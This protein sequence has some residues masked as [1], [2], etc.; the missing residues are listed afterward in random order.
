M[1]EQLDI[2]QFGGTTFRFPRYV[3]PG[4]PNGKPTRASTDAVDAHY[5]A[6]D[7]RDRVLAKAGQV[8]PVKVR[9]APRTYPA[10][11][12]ASNG[13]FVPKLGEPGATVTVDDGREGCVMFPA[14][15]VGEVWVSFWDGAWP[16]LVR[17]H[18]GDKTRGFLTGR[19]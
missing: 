8:R 6:V 15:D 12:K 13:V 4:H 19:R 16:S 9:K 7:R 14:P 17:F 10:H 1:A 2:F 3:E 11:V 5:K 18:S